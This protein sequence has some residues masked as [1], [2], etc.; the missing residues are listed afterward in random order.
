MSPHRAHCAASIVEHPFRAVR[1]DGYMRSVAAALEPELAESRAA[2]YPVSLEDMMFSI[3]IRATFISHS[4][5]MVLQQGRGRL[6]VAC[7]TTKG[8]ETLAIHGNDG[9]DTR[10]RYPITRSP[11]TLGDGDSG[12]YSIFEFASNE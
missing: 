1:V 11:P 3:T 12:N 10:E 9:V 5:S 8:R 7:A 6:A 4:Y 2:G